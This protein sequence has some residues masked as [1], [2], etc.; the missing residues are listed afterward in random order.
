VV[1]GVA[2]LGLISSL[3]ELDWDS[4]NDYLGI[5]ALHICIMFTESLRGNIFAKKFELIELKVDKGLRLDIG[6]DRDFLIC[7]FGA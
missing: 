6:L 3:D 5:Y 1:R 2:S 7:K 4:V